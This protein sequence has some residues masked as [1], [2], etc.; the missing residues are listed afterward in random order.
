MFYYTG[1]ASRVPDDD[2]EEFDDYD[3]ALCP[4]DYKTAGKILDDEINAT[5][6]RPL[7]RGAKLHAIIDS[8]YSGTVLDL[9][10]TCRMN[11]LLNF[12]F[13]VMLDRQIYS[14]Y[15]ALD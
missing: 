8:C 5:I 12:S 10:F 2:D 9:Y 7:P 15:N 1:H 4:V 11:R 14:T 13:G 6:V 3:E